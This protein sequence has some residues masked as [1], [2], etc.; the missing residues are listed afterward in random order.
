M[1]LQFLA[2]LC[3]KDFFWLFCDK[4]S[5]FTSQ[6][7]LDL[8]LHLLVR[9]PNAPARKTTFVQNS[10]TTTS[11]FWMAVFFWHITVTYRSRRDTDRLTTNFA[12]K[13]S[14]IQRQ[15]TTLRNLI[16]LHLLRINKLEV[17]Q[18]LLQFEILYERNLNFIIH[19]ISRENKI[20]KD[21]SI[22]EYFC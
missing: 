2:I 14:E 5:L 20:T 15:I 21:P 13:K 7:L 6:S 11:G 19:L 1:K 22:Y 18:E 10:V 8:Q 9:A 17:V 4:S 3:K 16:T 12:R